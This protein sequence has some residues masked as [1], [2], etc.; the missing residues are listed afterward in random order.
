MVAL[1]H[2]LRLPAGKRLGLQVPGGERLG[3]AESKEVDEESMPG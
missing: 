3:M 1:L 2:G